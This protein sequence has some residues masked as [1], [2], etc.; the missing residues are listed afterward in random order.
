MMAVVGY[1][2]QYEVKTIIVLYNVLDR[3][4]GPRR[5][6]DVGQCGL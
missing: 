6:P 3:G 1:T 5:T 2:I 4:L